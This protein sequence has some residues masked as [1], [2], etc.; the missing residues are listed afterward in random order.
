MATFSSLVE[1]ETKGELHAMV[2]VEV[3]GS[4]RMIERRRVIEWACCP[5]QR[6][7]REQGERAS[8][9]SVPDGSPKKDTYIINEIEHHQ[10]S[11]LKR[12]QGFRLIEKAG[13]SSASG[14]HS[15]DAEEEGGKGFG[16][17]YLVG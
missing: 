13:L 11:E 16:L 6:R 9:S 2:Q 4:D 15:S 3:R 8:S 14:S 7:K 17:T 5:S 12:R 1:A 10:S